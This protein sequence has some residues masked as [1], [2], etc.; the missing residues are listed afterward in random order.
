[1]HFA[2]DYAPAIYK[3]LTLDDMR[4]AKGIRSA[5]LDEEIGLHVGYCAK[6][7]ISEE[8][9]RGEPEAAHTA[10]AL[11][12]S[13]AD[14]SSSSWPRVAGRLWCCWKL[15][16]RVLL[17][18]GRRRVLVFTITMACRR[19]RYRSAEWPRSTRTA[20]YMRRI[21]GTTRWT[22]AASS[23]SAA[24]AAQPLTVR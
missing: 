10:K 19:R 13:S 14:E 18:N 7:G 15:R 16:V 6:W 2:R 9:M 8:Q 24:P 1:M 17:V 12:P 4:H 23:A 21:P 20:R 11:V 22:P 3:S 5:L